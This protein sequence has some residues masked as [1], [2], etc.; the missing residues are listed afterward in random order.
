MKIFK[1]DIIFKQFKIFLLRRKAAYMED[2]MKKTKKALLAAIAC[3]AVLA[4]SFG[5]AAC[6]KDDGDE[7]HTHSWSDWT[8]TIQPGKTT[9]GKATR[10]CNNP[11]CDATA[12]D[13]EYNDLPVLGSSDYT[14]GDNT[15][16]CT[17]A[18]T[19]HYTYNKN[20][21]EVEF[22]VATEI[23]PSAHSYT[24]G[25]YVDIDPEGHYQVCIYNEAHTSEKVAHTPADG[26]CTVCGFDPNHEHTFDNNTWDKDANG[27][28]H[29]TTCG[30][31]IKTEGFAVHV[32][33]GEWTEITPA[34]TTTEGLESNTC[35][36]CSYV[37][38]RAIPKLPQSVTGGE[39]EDGAVTL[40]VGKYSVVL[41]GVSGPY[42]YAYPQYF[43][44]VAGEEAKKYTLTV[45]S[46]VGVLNG[47]V[48]EPLDVVL[49]AGESYT[50]TVDGNE[51]G[52]EVVFTIEESEAPVAGSA[53][54][55]IIV[56]A[57][58]SYGKENADEDERV[59]IKLDHNSLGGSN[60][61]FTLGKDVE[62]YSIYADDLSTGAA[63]EKVT[64]GTPIE[65][66][67][68]Y[69]QYYYIVG[70]GGDCFVDFTVNYAEG[71]QYNP[72]EAIIGTG[73]ENVNTVSG[74]TWFKLD[75][76]GK[77]IITSSAEDVAVELYANVDGEP[78][79]ASYNG[80][81]L[82]VTVSAGAPVYIKGGLN[83][84]DRAT[85]TIKEYTDADKGTV[86]SEPIE[87]TPSDAVTVGGGERYYTY[88][89][90][91][92]GMV[93][94]T[95]NG[96]GDVIFWN[97]PNGFANQYGAPNDKNKLSVNVTAE[98]T[99]Y[100]KTVC[101][102]DVTGT[103]KFAAGEF[104][105]HDYVIT[106]TD[107]DED[108][109]LNLNDITVKLFNRN[110]D[111]ENDTPVATG[112]TTNGVVTFTGVDG[113]KDY[114]LVIDGLPATHGYYDYDMRVD[115]NIDE[116]TNFAALVY[117]KKDYSLTV[118]LPEGA[119]DGVS[120]A[121]IQVTFTDVNNSNASYTVTTNEQ[122]VATINV[123]DPIYI[124]NGYSNNSQFMVT[125][126]LTDALS[127]LYEKPSDGIYVSASRS[128]H[129]QQTGESVEVSNRDASVTLLAK[130]AYTLTLTDE[131][132]E[133]L[134]DG[135]T[136]TINGVSGTVANGQ[137]TIT[138]TAGEHDIIISGG[139]TTTVKTTAA[140]G[141][142]NVTCGK[143]VVGSSSSS[144]TLPELSMGSAQF[145]GNW[146]SDSY[147]KFV[148]AEAGTYTI[149]MTGANLANFNGGID[150]VNH[151]GTEIANGFNEYV[152]NTVLDSEYIFYY[153]GS[154]T[155]ELEANDV[156]VFGVRGEGTISITK[157]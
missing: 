11:G 78:V 128:E 41:D 130:V 7:G 42:G 109:T 122:G 95:F 8:V 9:K 15:A 123:L 108:T 57:S 20:G 3:S 30:H 2:S 149:T 157:A 145:V 120:L 124:Y 37:G 91:Q 60:V 12:A 83:E 49:E 133:A 104:A 43:K 115:S 84:W 6:G 70:R 66:G 81:P 75:T 131:S 59:Y 153:F 98:E 139:Y 44:I 24:E 97:Y 92:T 82:V 73:D 143:A 142:I 38:T 127:A 144:G 10:T 35:V 118:N 72:Y 112:T 45:T 140:G 56:K 94:F 1:K 148:A 14:K 116:T 74:A 58:G 147:C 53:L 28:W 39:D 151:N 79:D 19:Q 113:S 89:A 33:E 135:T 137:V 67:E 4:G 40:G 111:V 93:T 110:D 22:D 126:T 23:N 96:E 129:N 136:V 134:P 86:A 154:I 36:T 55:P 119:A 114:K 64:V 107:G 48:I 141:D 34:T 54:R 156:L 102:E 26:V 77:Y 16:T 32:Y 25:E 29:P 5:L 18:G 51:I 50:F 27:H 125:Y 117:A 100:F 65:V 63:G 155:V 99:Y 31:N 146:N 103:F 85:I 106:L 152:G 90:T 13:K 132:G 69:D 105:A 150:T 62:L 71:S 121:G 76:A 47:Y 138:T 52:D 80:S 88:T 101:D 17:T 87:L 46:D 61:S 21:V 68:W